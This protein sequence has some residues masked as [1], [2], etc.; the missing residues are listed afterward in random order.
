M[1]YF[2]TKPDEVFLAILDEAL[3]GGL[4]EVNLISIEED[5][6]A[7]EGIFPVSADWVTPDSAVLVIKQLI[8]LTHYEEFS[9]SL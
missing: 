7:W 4:A 3:A 9:C 8:A 1:I 2:Q 6:E 5:L